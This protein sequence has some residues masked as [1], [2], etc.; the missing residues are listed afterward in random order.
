[1]AGAIISSQGPERLEILGGPRQ[2]PDIHYW[3]LIYWEFQCSPGTSKGA[4]LTPHERCEN[5]EKYP[6]VKAAKTV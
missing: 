1:M 4:C 5:C 6:H 3:I 2:A